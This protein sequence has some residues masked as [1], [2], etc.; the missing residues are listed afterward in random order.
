VKT[1]YYALV[2][3]IIFAVIGVAG[4]IPGLLSPLDP[5]AD[6]AV[7]ALSGRLLGLFPVNVLHS[8]VHLLF[9]IWGIAAYRSFRASRGYAKSVAVIYAVL[10]IMG[11]IPFLRTTF[12]LI[13]LYGH[14]IWLHALI[15]ISAAYFGF[16]ADERAEDRDAVTYRS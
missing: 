14:D 11:F 8:I 16:M 3:G 1:R 6:L 2:M 9:G 12:G 15:A 7:T 5:G 4:F 13:P 10:L